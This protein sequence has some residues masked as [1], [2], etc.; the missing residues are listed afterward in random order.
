MIIEISTNKK[1]YF[2]RL[3]E[4]LNP[5]L[6]LSP[7]EVKVIALTAEE[8]YDNLEKVKDEDLAWRLTMD[9]DAKAKVRERLGDMSY[10]SHA[11]ILTSLREKK[12]L[13]NNKLVKPFLLP[14]DKEL[15]FKFKISEEGSDNKG[16]SK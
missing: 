8:F 15:I 7:Q 14:K 4:L 13:V 6:K 2:T 16:H 11:N 3:Y 12:M 10:N 9:Y 1:D 5:F